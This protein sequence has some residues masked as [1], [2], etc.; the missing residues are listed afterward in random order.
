MKPTATI[1][2]SQDASLKEQNALLENLKNS[3]DF[4]DIKV[5]TSRLKGRAI[6]LVDIKGVRN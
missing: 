3:Y 5:L 6:V 4:V 1:Y 2:I